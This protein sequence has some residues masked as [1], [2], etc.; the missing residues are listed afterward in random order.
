MDAVLALGTGVLP[1]PQD[2]LMH[3]P[4]SAHAHLTQIPVHWQGLVNL[5]TWKMYHL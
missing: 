5:L 1:L 4:K 3:S 2:P